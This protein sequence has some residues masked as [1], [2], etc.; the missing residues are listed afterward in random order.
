[1]L[2]Q[3]GELFHIFSFD[4]KYDDDARIHE[5]RD[6]NLKKKFRFFS[7]SFSRKHERPVRRF[8]D[9]AVYI[10]FT[11]HI[12][13]FGEMETLSYIPIYPTYIFF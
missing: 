4:R 13:D 3:T 12:Y 5:Y 2:Y 11:I 7:R 1:M 10:T 8:A 6:T 9:A